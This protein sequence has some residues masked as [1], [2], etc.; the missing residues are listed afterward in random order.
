MGEARCFVIQRFDNGVYDQRYVE[1]F[2]PAIANGGATPVRA[3]EVLGTKPVVE[4]IE[5]G[6]RSSDVAFAEISEDNANVFLELGYALALGIPTVIVCDK[7]KRNSL[8]FDIAHRPVNFYK[9]D[10]SSGFDKIS[11]EVTNAISAAIIESRSAAN[12]EID[13]KNTPTKIDEDDVKSICLLILLDRSLRS[14]S[15]SPL[16]DIQKD[17]APLGLSERMVSLAITS[18]LDDNLIKS[19]SQENAYDE[20]LTFALTE[21][22]QKYV[23]RSYKEMMSAERERVTR[24]PI[25]SGFK[26][27]G[28]DEFY[29]DVP[30]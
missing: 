16:W 10:T 28:D 26:K 7:S 12:F 23:L 29:D 27:T 11:K 15:G 21:H 1:T 19:F 25:L 24:E 2:A 17:A 22:G 9:T 6:L 5:Q 4:K 30:F 14:P 3:D 13:I 8:P 20:F 18:L